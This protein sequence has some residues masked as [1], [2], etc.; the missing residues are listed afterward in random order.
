ML[1]EYSVKE[2]QCRFGQVVL[3]NIYSAFANRSIWNLYVQTIKKPK[4]LQLGVYLHRQSP[5]E[6]LPPASAPPPPPI[7]TSTADPSESLGHPLMRA[8]TTGN[9]T[10]PG[11]SAGASV[12][13]STPQR[14]RSRALSAGL[15]HSA[16]FYP[17]SPST[18]VGTTT[19]TGTGTAIGTGASFLFTGAGSSSAVATTTPLRAGAVGGGGGGNPGSPTTSP[20][21]S[22]TGTHFA[23][24]AMLG[25]SVAAG[26]GANSSNANAHASSVP[27]A[28]PLVPYRDPRKVLRAYFSIHCP[29]PL[30]NALTRFSSGP[31]HFTVSQS[32]GWK[33]SS[34]SSFPNLG[35]GAGAGAS[36][37][38]DGLKEG[39]KE[40]DKFRCTVVLGLV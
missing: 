17:S 8:T 15:S 30:G 38:M 24:S 23:P 35:V 3:M 13:V 21:G 4:G 5:L 12:G 28:A 32:W 10:S 18:P 16:V 27:S 39:K 20:V 31:D 25:G 37:G 6:P 29:S 34:L 33:S 22:P 14:G 40:S 9:A 1:G 26:G 36:A 2:S 19:T 7:P 11:A